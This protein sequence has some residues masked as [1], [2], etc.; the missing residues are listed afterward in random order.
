MLWG[1][2]FVSILVAAVTS[3]FVARAERERAQADKLD[4]AAA[5]DREQA[6]FDD[7]MARLDRIEQGLSQLPKAWPREPEITLI[8]WAG[9]G[10]VERVLEQAEFNGAFD[11]L[12]AR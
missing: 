11:R 2:A 5:D 7:L 1:I 6:R 8:G 9:S 3:T 12:G 4:K 10:R